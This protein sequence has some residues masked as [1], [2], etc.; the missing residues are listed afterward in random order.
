[1]NPNNFLQD[2]EFPGQS[3][4]LAWDAIRD[5]MMP[6]LSALLGFQQQLLFLKEK[7]FILNG[8]NKIPATFF[9]RKRVAG[10]AN[11][12]NLFMGTSKNASVEACEFFN[13]EVYWGK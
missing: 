2:S 12:L 10:I 6:C 13:F 7:I 1:V 3:L 11:Q 8:P 9:F 4:H 5:W